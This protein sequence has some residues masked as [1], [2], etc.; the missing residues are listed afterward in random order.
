MIGF[1]KTK[2]G[3]S[4]ICIVLLLVLLS[5][6]IVIQPIP[7][8]LS[9]E[10]LSAPQ[11]MSELQMTPGQ[12]YVSDNFET[13]L[14]LV[15]IDTGD[16][17]PHPGSV[18]DEQKGYP[19]AVD[20][21]PYAYGTIRIID[22]VNDLNCVTDE[23][24]LQ[25]SVKLRIRGNSS[26][27]YPKKQYL[28]KLIDEN[29]NNNPQ[30]VLNMGT[31]N[32]WILNISWQDPSLMRNYLAYTLAKQTTLLSPDAEYCE[33]LYKNG[34]D[35]EYLGVYLMMEN[36]KRSKQRVDIPTYSSNQTLSF[37]MRRDR[38]D[39]D[40]A[41]LK[42]Y[43]LMNGYT[44]EYFEVLYPSQ[45][46]VTSEDIARMEN[47]INE[48]EEKLYSK[49]IDMFL[50]Y[51]DYINIDTFIDYFIF[52]EFLMNY[53]AGRFSTYFYRDYTGKISMGPVW[54]FDR[55]LANDPVY[56]GEMY[57]TALQSSPWFDQMLRDPNFV[58]KVIDRY[59]EL[60]EDALSVEKIEA[61]IAGADA[62]LGTAA[63]RDW[64]RWQYDKNVG[65][66]PSFQAPTSIKEEEEN[67]KSVFARHGSWLDKRIDSLYQFCET[68]ID[69]IEPELANEE[70][71][72]AFSEF[73]AVIFL[74]AVVISALLLRREA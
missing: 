65:D 49:D 71:A 45:N 16:E 17:E 56:V 14:P 25:S 64:Y 1:L 62:Y 19:V 53:D 12:R 13:H 36:V 22:N 20:Y 35:F 66:R 21:D 4:V 74:A 63:Q 50:Q 28:V 40:G 23:A 52:N 41:I 55:S 68:G 73:L 2:L 34:S 54:D 29:G 8:K 67:I 72:N 59:H 30:D 18:W 6:L 7:E 24:A 37:I 60:R 70:K 38:Y 32:E 15:I 57:T 58:K 33:V 5:G 47:L 3:T 42:T 69:P 51:R 31:D 9:T 48:F 11:K 61:L 46:K 44:T 43:G 10:P 27:A 26:S 39:E